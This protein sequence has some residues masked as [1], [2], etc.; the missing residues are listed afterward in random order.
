[1]KFT[2]SKASW[3]LLLA[4][5]TSLNAAPILTPRQPTQL[6]HWPPAAADALNA[7]ISANAN[8]GNYAVFDMDNTS[9]RYDLEESLLPF[10]E[11]RGIITREG[12]DPSLKLI[13]FKDTANY[14]ETLFSY[15][16]RLCEIDDKVCYPWVAQ[17]FSNFTLGELK[18]YVDELM[19][20]EGNITSTYY[21]EDVVTNITVNRPRIF[22]GQVELYNVLRY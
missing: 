13:E 4:G 5:A 15:Y 9:Y 8:Q 18:G 14:T 17:V 1:M 19:T 3:L 7:M 11:G 2:S 10:L 20:F 6:I 12:L 22:A 16:Y 21:D